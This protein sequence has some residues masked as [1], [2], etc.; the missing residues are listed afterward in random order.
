MSAL[1]VKIPEINTD[2]NVGDL[3]EPCGWQ[4]LLL[5]PKVEEKTD[6]GVFVT[7]D[8]KRREE[9]A[10]NLAYVLKMGPLCYKGEKYGNDP[11]VEEGDWV[12][13]NPYSG[14]KC[15]AMIDGDKYELRI[16]NDEHVR[17]KVPQPGLIRRI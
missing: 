8:Q 16:I 1:K 10:T 9:E 14:I 11:W 17:A 2:A 3:P 4:M 5:I 6:G 7:E 12:L 15:Y 13:I